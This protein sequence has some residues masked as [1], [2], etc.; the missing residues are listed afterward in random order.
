MQEG[1]LRQDHRCRQNSLTRRGRRPNGPPYGS[2]QGPYTSNVLFFLYSCVLAHIFIHVLRYLLNIRLWFPKKKQSESTLDIRFW[3]PKK[4]Q[5]D[6]KTQRL[7]RF[8]LIFP[9]MSS[10]CCVDCHP[11]RYLLLFFFCIVRSCL[12]SGSITDKKPSVFADGKEKVCW[13]ENIFFSEF[14]RF[15]PLPVLVLE[16][17]NYRDR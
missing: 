1:I 2:Y 6:S 5:S 9:I 13:S 3:F 11:F 16:L 17:S 7:H 4:K 8:H 10:Q 15:L 12:F 14:L